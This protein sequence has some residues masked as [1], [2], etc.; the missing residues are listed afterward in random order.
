MATVDSK[1]GVANGRFCDY[2][3]SDRLPVR[4]V[5]VRFAEE[6]GLNMA[7]VS[8]APN[9]GQWFDPI[10]DLVIGVTVRS[11]GSQIIRDKGSCKGFSCP[12][13]SII[14]TPPHTPSY[15]RFDGNPDVL[16]FVVPTNALT[17][18]FDGEDYARMGENFGHFPSGDTI[19]PNLAKRLWNLAGAGDG[20][21]SGTLARCGIGTVLALL[22]EMSKT[23]T[24][25]ESQ[26]TSPLNR[27]QVHKVET[28]VLQ[29]ERRVSVEDLAQEL[30]LSSDHFARAFKAATGHSP[31]KMVSERRIN[32]AKR[33][34]TETGQPITEIALE[35]GFSSSAHFSTRFRELAGMSPSRWRK[36]YNA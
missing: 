35:L 23:T 4:N 1:L 32:E 5:E 3:S 31:Y 15:W 16:Y 25:I 12:S 2:L 19:I 24:A 9:S 11:G 17:G 22:L 28:L 26:K 30:K 13:G 14:V 10:K 33:L 34:L 36:I 20:G 7:M 21:L 27:R 18:L 29:P 8:H 6:T